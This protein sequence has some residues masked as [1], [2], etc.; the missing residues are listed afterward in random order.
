MNYSEI[1][2][3]IEAEVSTF[4]PVIAEIGVGEKSMWRLS[5]GLQKAIRRGN[6]ENALEVAKALYKEAPWYAWKRLP[7]V[8]IED[9]GHGDH[10]VVEKVL[11]AARNIGW[12]KGFGDEKV[13]LWLIQEVTEAVKDRSTCDLLGA[14]A[15]HPD[16]AEMR[17][18]MAILASFQRELLV[19]KAIH[20]GVPLLKRALALVYLGG[21]PNKPVGGL[22]ANIPGSIE[23]VMEVISVPKPI[24]DLIRLG[25]S[26]KVGEMMSLYGLTYLMATE[27]PWK[28]EDDPGSENATKVGPYLASSFDMYTAEGKRAIGYFLVVRKNLR[29]A[30]F[31]A[32]LEKN[33]H[34][35]AVGMVLFFIESEKLRRRMIHGRTW[36][37]RELDWDA[38]MK[39]L[40]VNPE[41]ANLIIAELSEHSALLLK[42]RTKM[43][44]N[45]PKPKEKK[46]A[47]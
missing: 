31:A 1:L 36:E 29:E 20:P 28:V 17:R 45:P 30:L 27:L 16:L 18:D 46:E 44:E 47:V 13:Y 8:T 40:G 26:L 22:E 5:S 41:L 9:V 23:A 32:G 35:A 3:S 33:K 12:R 24:E 38:S 15:D 34:V 11:V 14:V 37:L 4:E 25:V 19:E 10:G 2:K 6:V 21:T 7:A 42:A 39:N 43:F